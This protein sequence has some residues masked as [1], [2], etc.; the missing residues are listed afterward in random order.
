MNTL[1]NTIL[2]CCLSILFYGCSI[3]DDFSSGNQEEDLELLQEL[4][5]DI[6]LMA[7][8]PCTDETE[9]EFVAYGSKACGG[10]QGYIAYP[11]T[12]DVEAFLLLVENYTTEEA[13]FNANY[14]IASTC[15]V[16]AVP[17]DVVCEEGVAVLV[18]E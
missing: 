7:D 15:D 12:I 6:T 4:F 8:A 11:T 14:G 17:I 18:Y 1:K 2:L 9:W 5:A 16:P 10:P 3:D 13:I